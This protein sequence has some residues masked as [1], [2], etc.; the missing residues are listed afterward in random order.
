M[1]VTPNDLTDTNF[2]LASALQSLVQYQL[3][4]HNYMVKFRKTK[5][6]IKGVKTFLMT[7]QDHQKSNFAEGPKFELH[8]VHSR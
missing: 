8:R 3:I 4:P 5:S 6:F 7:P 1:N 2:N